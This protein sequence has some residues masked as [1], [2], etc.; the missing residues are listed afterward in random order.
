LPELKFARPDVLCTFVKAQRDVEDIDGDASEHPVDFS[1]YVN[2]VRTSQPL[3]LQSDPRQTP[4]AVSPR[5]S[6]EIVS[7]LFRTMGPRVIFVEDHGLLVGLITVKDL[8]KQNML[9]EH[10]AKAD[11]SSRINELEDVLEEGRLWVQGFLDRFWKRRKPV[12]TSGSPTVVFDA[13]RDS[14]E[15]PERPRS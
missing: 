3:W 12:S 1:S 13:A 6:I 15:L 5:Q 14:Y 8:L 7:E 2:E 11:E 9:H 4:L 10:Q